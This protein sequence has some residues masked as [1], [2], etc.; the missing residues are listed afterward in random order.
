[1]KTLFINILLS[2]IFF[3]LISADYSIAIGIN[4]AIN[5]ERIGAAE[6]TSNETIELIVRDAVSR[7]P[8]AHILYRYGDQQGSTGAQGVIRVNLRENVRLELSHVSY[9]SRTL[10]NADIRLAT[11]SGAFYWM[12]RTTQMQPVTVV[13]VRPG[14][15]SR[16]VMT[17]ET[18]DKLS[19]DA[20]SF[21]QNLAAFSGVR[22]S[23]GYG[24]DPVL[25]G[26]K[27]DQLN[28]VIDGSMSASAACPNR[29]DPPTSQVAMSMIERVEVLKGPYALRFG[30]GFG[31]T[32]NFISA[33]P[34][35]SE[36]LTPYGRFSGSVESNNAVYRTEAVA[37]VRTAQTDVS[38][39]GSWSEAASYTDGRGQR[40]ASGFERGSYG[41]KSAIRANDAHR[42]DVSLQRN[43]ASDTQFPS[44][45][46]DLISDKTWMGSATWQ[47]TPGDTRSHNS[48]MEARTGYRQSARATTSAQHVDIPST[49]TH[50]QTTEAT[51]M[52]GARAGILHHVEANLWFSYVDHF[53]SN[54]LRELNPR[55]VNAGTQAETLNFGARSE[56]QLNMPR[57]GKT[58]VG[59]DFRSEQAEGIREREMLMGPM[60]GNTFFDNAWQKSRIQNTG[61][62]AEMQQ[63]AGDYRFVASA[64]LDVNHAEALDPDERFLTT[65]NELKVTQINPSLSAGIIRSWGN[66]LETGFWAGRSVRSAGITE[67]YI[68]FFPVGLDPYEMLGNPSLKQEVN[69]QADVIFS[70]NTAALRAEINLFQSLI[71]NYISSQIDPD[72]APRMGTAPGVRRYVNLDRAWLGGVE[73]SL[74]QLI[75]PYINH[76]AQ[77][78]W[79]YGENLDSNEALPEIAPLDLRYRVGL[80]LWDGRV[81]PELSV[82]HVRAQD[83]V[84]ESFG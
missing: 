45:A 15:Q 29:M 26:F 53:M 52:P 58:Y 4:Q 1:M 59:L 19:H 64:R 16:T 61:I 65:T 11:A 27:Y 80:I 57:G 82:R 83:R 41:M 10:T 9:G 3:G 81:H 8:V 71:T 23:G 36:G 22:K 2:F 33:S 32:I 5:S 79:T 84:S 28:V 12:E 76:G 77:L 20:G 13:S 31:G 14:E 34:E 66:T 6:A 24:F 7:Q 17:L 38:L 18:G 30:N 55:M 74:N 46:M 56:A 68:N 49:G 75:G 40:I 51:L 47:Y 78:A 43:V 60:A 39:F 37:G 44:L 54:E 63:S 42:V 72:L 73:V 62:F 70:W 21:L 25:R 67:R 35:F 48:N 50:A 69:H